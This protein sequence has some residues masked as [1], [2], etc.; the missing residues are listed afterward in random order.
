[1]GQ[2]ALCFPCSIIGNMWGSCL[3]A[4]AEKGDQLL[5]TFQ[6]HMRAVPGL[7]REQWETIGEGSATVCIPSNRNAD[8]D[9]SEC[10]SG[11]IFLI[12][13]PIWILS[14]RARV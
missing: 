11:N 2:P 5:R 3:V 9:T 10:G 8:S 4:A 1:M 12:H 7:Q 13:K 14:L 6:A